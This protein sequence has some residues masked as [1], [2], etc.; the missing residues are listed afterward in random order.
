[1]PL[2]AD[3]KRT[4]LQLARAAVFAAARQQD[5]PDLRLEGLPPALQKPGACFV[6]LTLYGELRGCIGSLQAVRPLA[7]DVQQQAMLTALYDYRF[8]TLTPDELP[9]IEVEISVLS[10]PQPLPYADGADLARKLRPAVDGLILSSEDHRATFLP[11]VW[12][13]VPRV[14]DFLNLLCEKM[15]LPPNEWRYGQLAASVYQVDKFTERE[16][17]QG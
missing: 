2:T 4:L 17:G 7:Q 12:E 9:G 10:E 13:R 8:G 11:Q 14:E 15:G 1:M 5:P 16:F 6:T 3:E